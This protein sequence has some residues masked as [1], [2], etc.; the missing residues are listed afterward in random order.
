MKL[1]DAVFGLLLLALGAAVIAVV[2]SYPTIPAQRVGPALFPGLIALGLASG[3]LILIVRGWRERAKV[4]WL[5]FEPW[6]RSPR[7]VAGVLG[8]IGSVIFYIVAVDWLGFFLT[9]L[10][11]LV[12]SFRLFGVPLGKS[13]VIAAIATMV[14]HFAFYKLLR[15]P[16]PWGLFTNYAW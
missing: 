11:I 6:V 14:I 13:I 12:T 2:A 15:V 16:L 3:G 8:V 10:V 5:R 4:P 1:S 9:S 7:H